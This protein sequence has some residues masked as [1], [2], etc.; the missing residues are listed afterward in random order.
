MK[1]NLL[2]NKKVAII[3]GGPVGLTTAILLQQ[4]DVDVTVYERDLNAQTRISGGTLDIDKN[5]GQLALRKAGL[6][7]V[8]YKYARPTGER[9]IDINAN[10]L[11]EEMPTA[12]NKF[13]KPEID[14]NDLRDMLLDN[15]N[16]DTVV[17]NSQI[18]SIK[19]KNNQYTLLLQNGSETIADFIIIANGGMS[20][21]RKYVTEVVPHYTGTYLIQG[22]VLEPEKNCPSFKKLCG[23]ENT[24]AVVDKKMFFC[25]VKAK[26]VLQYYLSFK[27]DENWIEK[28]NMDFSNKQMVL[29]FLDELMVNW[30]PTY[31][32][33]FYATDNFVALPMRKMPLD[34]PWDSQSDI[35]LV[36]DTAHLMP[37]FGGVGVNMGLL[38]ALHLATNLTEGDFPDTLSAVKDYEQKMLV[39][40]GNAQQQTGKGEV[41]IH[42][43]ISFDDLQKNRKDK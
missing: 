28:K 35:T 31:K 41:M 43:D 10:I 39:Y 12:E 18:V 33:L 11:E 17:W 3:G 26:G 13:D 19:K 21:L 22:E 7:E 25:Q 24:I 37:P 16:K 36:G 38:D 27:T 5:T 2:A 9:N 1:N 14:R 20:K 40:A 34:K 15:L 6:L 8:F 30:H 42:S 4:K 29:T 32:E 23:E